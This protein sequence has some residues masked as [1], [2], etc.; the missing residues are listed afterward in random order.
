MWIMLFLGVIICAQPGQAFEFQGFGDVSV[1]SR[2]N[3]SG[4][5][6]NNGAFQIG[7]LDLFATQPVSDRLNLLSEIVILGQ[8]SGAF[9]ISVERFQIGYLLSDALILYAGRFHTPIGYWN[10][11]YHHGAY[12][13]TTIDRPNVLSQLPLHLI[14]LWAGGMHTLGPVLMEFDV[15]VGNGDK[16]VA[17]KVISNTVSDNNGNKAALYRLSL[18]SA[19]FPRA[20]IGTSGYFSQ[21]EIFNAT[22]TTLLDEV[23]QTLLG[24]Y[25]FYDNKPLQVIGESYYMLNHQRLKL[26]QDH[27]RDWAY[28]LQGGITFFKKV[29]PYVRFEQTNVDQG[30]PYFSALTGKDLQ[31]LIGGVRFEVTNQSAIKVEGRYIDPKGQDSYNEYGAQ[32][33][34]SY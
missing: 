14:G 15:M 7:Q 12:F 34:V 26:P 16:V 33:S 4:A 32:W 20:G 18:H 11:T 2:A 22:E 10:A 1:V 29:T 24:L 31:R 25:F 27:Y 9:N 23:K 21:I 17:D 8:K 13:Q 30:D 19:S 6:P 3:S 28:F 5:D